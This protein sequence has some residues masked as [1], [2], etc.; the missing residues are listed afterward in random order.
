MKNSSIKEKYPNSM[1]KAQ[2]KMS[3]RKKLLIVL[4]VVLS[5]ILIPI[6][7][8]AGLFFYYAKDAPTLDYKK[9]EDTRSS[10]MYA[11][12]GD[13]FL[14]I[15][16]K[17]RETIEPNQI[18][19]MLKQAIISI[20]D[21]RFEKHAGVDPIRI[22]GAA[23]AN[24]KGT[25]KQGGSTLTQQLI[26][27]SFFSTKKEDQT[28][29]RKAQEAWLSI[30]LERS[31]SKDEILTYYINRVYMANGVYGM[32][33]AAE[34]YFNKNLDELSLAQYALLAGMP[35]A[36]TDYDPYTQPELA[37]KRRNLVLSE[38][39]K[40]KVIS[41]NEY[42]E[43]INTKVD[44]G[45]VPLKKDSSTQVVTDNYVKQVIDEVQKKTNK[46]VY[47]Y[48]LDIY[49]N[50][51]LD[52][53]NYL[54]NLVNNK[55]SSINFPD[56]EFQATATLIDVKNGDVRA[57]IGGRNLG[58]GAMNENL[59][60]TAKRNIGSTAKPLVAYA[61]TIE[62]LS[63]GSGQ[64]YSDMPYKYS[65]GT[66]VYDYDRSYRGNLT[67]RESLVDSRNIPALKALKEVGNDTSKEFISN[68]GFDNNVYEGTAIGFESSTEK[69]AAAYAAFANGGV[70]YEPSYVSKIVYADG[71]EESFEPNGKR[72]MK[73]STAFIITDMLKDVITRGTGNP[74]QIDG[75]VQA[76][77][78]GT[79]NYPDDVLDKIKGT[80]QGSP[81]ITFAGYTPKYSLAVWTGY[82]DYFQPIVYSD[83]QLAMDIYRN[84]MSYLYQDLEATDWK[85]P[86]D[87]VRMGSEVYIK[88]H[89]KQTYPS[90]DYQTY[91][92]YYYENETQTETVPSQSKEQ[93]SESKENT[94]TEQTQE[95]PTHESQPSVNDNGNTVVTPPQT[96]QP[97]V[98]NRS[99]KEE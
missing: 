1:K 85:Q 7:G 60:V 86:S 21:K 95:T 45:L 74:A 35:Q 2:K 17:K 80:G 23:I 56:D 93:V 58:D 10:K 49:T 63:Y 27:L 61:P 28:L 76:G 54:Y 69:L 44:D 36:P 72:A 71:T 39:L 91:S 48:G 89:T 87:V 52:A 25:S 13:M 88:G 97:Q 33:T 81:D 55:D 96:S 99:K 77:K 67:M 47:T 15:G 70:Y 4:I 66:P 59:A 12:N 64:I 5:L 3:T 18:P 43:A 8:G 98:N 14:E 20:E 53:Q 82:K 73:E 90:Y 30:E 83:Q 41:Q 37:T 9:L 57:Q 16:E 32:Q 31:K 11:A 19:P 75:I 38:M 50:I 40:D 62:D 51:D 22:G 24:L 84:F 26:K 65:D 79:S 29:K 46:N 78:T 6:V 68:L 34:T 92:N 42:D 94:V